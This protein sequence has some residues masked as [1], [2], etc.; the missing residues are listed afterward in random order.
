MGAGLEF[1]SELCRQARSPGTTY[2]EQAQTPGLDELRTGPKGLHL[3][4]EQAS[5]WSNKAFKVPIPSGTKLPAHGQGH[6]QHTRSRAS[7]GS[8][9]LSSPAKRKD[10]EGARGGQEEPVLS[11]CNELSGTR[12]LRA[13][14][15][16]L[17]LSL[18]AG[19]LGSSPHSHLSYP[20]HVRPNTKSILAPQPPLPLTLAPK[21]S[22]FPAFTSLQSTAPPPAGGGS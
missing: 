13:G 5:S 19:S 4:A 21:A 1:P 12:W 22:I 8:H 3:P 18:R 15:P 2:W 16:S 9:I 20:P 11:V 10:G 6:T 7:A 14:A 17:L